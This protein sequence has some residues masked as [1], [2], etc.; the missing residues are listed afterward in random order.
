MAESKTLYSIYILKTSESSQQ[1][2]K[3]IINLGPTTL[4]RMF[5]HSSKQLIIDFGCLNSWENWV[6]KCCNICL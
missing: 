5:P 1:N 6:E 4:I 3:F 2:L